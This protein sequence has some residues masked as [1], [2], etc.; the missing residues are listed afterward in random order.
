MEG[1]SD[2]NLCPKNFSATSIYSGTPTRD[3]VVVYTGVF[4]SSTPVPV[5]VPPNVLLCLSSAVDVR[6]LT[7]ESSLVGTSA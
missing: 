5:C 7:P 2:V 6:V 3:W 1:Y 4:S